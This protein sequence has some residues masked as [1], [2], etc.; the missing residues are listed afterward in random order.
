M[1]KYYV[2]MDDGRAG[3]SWWQDKRGAE[4]FA[5]NFRRC[6]KFAMIVSVRFKHPMMPSCH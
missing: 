2:I 6:G 4:M 5:R 3:G 1:T